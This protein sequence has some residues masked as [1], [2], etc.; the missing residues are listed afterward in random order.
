MFRFKKICKAKKPSKVGP[1]PSDL[2]M[3]MDLYSVPVPQR[4]DNVKKVRHIARVVCLYRREVL[5][6][7][8]VAVCSGIPR[9]LMH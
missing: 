4:S 6:M 3:V 1:Y 5:I 8:N 9:V 7:V 2:Q